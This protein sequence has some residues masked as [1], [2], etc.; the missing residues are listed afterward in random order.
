MPWDIE[1]IACVNAF[2]KDKFDQIF[3]QANI[4][5]GKLFS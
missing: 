5:D 2:A 1:E 3:N 4:N